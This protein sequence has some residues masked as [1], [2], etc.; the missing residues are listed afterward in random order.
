M[1]NYSAKRKKTSSNIFYHDCKILE[2]EIEIA[3]AFHNY[4]TSI[5][6]S[7][8]NKF[9][10]NNN[11]L[12]Y[13]DDAPNCRLYFEPVEEPYIIKILDKHKNKKSSGIDGISNCLIN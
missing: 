3:N 5:G 9:D 13:F 2:D 7:L 8:A 1:K 6:P 10:Q 12:K 4:F 11:Y